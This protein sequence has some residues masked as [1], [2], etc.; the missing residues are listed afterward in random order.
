M[1]IN[2]IDIGSTLKRVLS[3]NRLGAC[4]FHFHWEGSFPSDERLGGR[5][6]IIGIIEVGYLPGGKFVGF[7][8]SRHISRM[9]ITKTNSTD[10][11]TIPEIIRWEIISPGM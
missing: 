2:L 11:R 1:K 3:L 4:Q 7:L 5:D 8:E 9:R 10:G 6:E